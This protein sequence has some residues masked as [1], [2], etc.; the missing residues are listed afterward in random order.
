MRLFI[1]IAFLIFLVSC[2]PKVTS[3]YVVDENQIH[4]ETFSF[5]AREQ[6]D[7]NLQKAELD[8]LIEKAITQKLI[9]KGYVKTYPSNIYV[10]Y[11]IMSDKTFKTHTQG[12]YNPVVPNFNNMPYDNFIYITEHKEGILIIEFYNENDKLLWQGSKS[13]KVRK[14][15]NTQEL[16]IMYAKEITASFKPNL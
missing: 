11:K 3:F 4:V 2:S 7:L 14:S 12:T 5:Y 6:Q 1:Y 8:S 16:L 9:N 15:I 10:S 13:F